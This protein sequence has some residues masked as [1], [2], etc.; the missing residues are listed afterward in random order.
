M[1]TAHN[2]SMTRQSYTNVHAR[3]KLH[4]SSCLSLSPPPPHADSFC[5]LFPWLLLFKIVTK[6]LIFQA[7]RVMIFY[8]E[9]V[10]CMLTCRDTVSY[11]MLSQHLGSCLNICWLSFQLILKK[12]K[13]LL[14]HA[15]HDGKTALYWMT[16]DI[17]KQDVH[18]ILGWTL[19]LHC[20][21]IHL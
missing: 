3:S 7:G 19:F 20:C 8:N 2:L 18:I 5:N 21:T 9:T 6:L 10:K 12:N 11:G 15:V 13:R 14:L 1:G 16:E 4:S 17:F